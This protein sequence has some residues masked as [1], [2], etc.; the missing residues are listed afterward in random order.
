DG[1]GLAPREPDDDGERALRGDQ[2]RVGVR[3]VRDAA[4]RLP[5]DADG[6]GRERLLGR[7]ADRE[8]PARGEGE[9]EVDEAAR[10]LRAALERDDEAPARGGDEPRAE[11]ARGA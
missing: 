7:D 2:V 3:A 5:V 4:Q 1:R 6:D 9:A 11:L 10:R 8:R